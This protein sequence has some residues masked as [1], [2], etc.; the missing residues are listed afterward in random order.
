MTT[1]T[2]PTTTDSCSKHAPVVGIVGGIGAGKSALTRFASEQMQVAVVDA[3]SIGHQALRIPE[4]KERILEAFSDVVSDPSSILVDG[5]INR[6]VLGALVWGAD[7]ISRERR[8]TLEQIVHP[9]MVERFSELFQE[10]QQSGQC[11]VILFD[12]A[13]LLEAGWDKLCDAVI[14]I[15]CADATRLQRVS[16]QRGWNNEQLWIRE[17][18]Q[19][20]LETK[21]AQ[22]SLI[23]DNNQP[24]EVSGREFVLALHQIAPQERG[25]A[26]PSSFPHVTTN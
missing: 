13:I 17:Q 5:Q 4:L 25:P 15:E 24:L 21:K 23:I 6:Q 12:A 10:Y 18:S 14:Y 8:T 22:A 20:P 11:D 19:W 1:V 9:W 7:P 2:T 3:D 26:S 16:Q